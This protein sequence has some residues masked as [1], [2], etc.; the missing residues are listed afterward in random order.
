MKTSPKIGASS[1][2][3]APPHSNELIDRAHRP[4]PNEP[5]RVRW[6]PAQ[7]GLRHDSELAARGASNLANGSIRTPTG[8]PP[9]TDAH[10][11]TR[12]LG[13]PTTATHSTTSP[14]ERR[15]CAPNGPDTLDL[16]LN[17]PSAHARANTHTA[18]NHFRPH[19]P[20]RFIPASKH[21]LSLHARQ[22]FRWVRS[23]GQRPN[24]AN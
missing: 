9:Q 24:T 6:P 19:L 5:A 15:P 7:I 23:T 8:G 12:F 17:I 11:H 22:W 18:K 10:T 13:A 21:L 2:P 16:V 3:L 1:R 20:S 4:R 14:L